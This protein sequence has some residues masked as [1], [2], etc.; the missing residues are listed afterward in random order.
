MLK[1]ALK[2][3]GGD[4]H[5]RVDVVVFNEENGAIKAGARGE[6]NGMNENV[7]LFSGM[8]G[9]KGREK[10]LRGVVRSDIERVKTSNGRQLILEFEHTAHESLLVPQ[11]E[12]CLLYTS[13]S[14]RDRQKS[15]M[16]SSA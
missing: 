1:A 16:P 14:P 6:A 2:G 13:P 12:G 7:G 3:I 11:I 5:R 9:S 4:R 15:R 8:V 10:F